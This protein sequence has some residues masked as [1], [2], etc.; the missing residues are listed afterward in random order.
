M[1]K[2]SDVVPVQPPIQQPQ[3]V[4]PVQY[5][6]PA[7]PIQSGQPAQPI[8]SGQPNPQMEQIKKSAT[9]YFSFFIQMLKAPVRTGQ[10]T[11]AGQMVNGLITMIVFSLML[12]LTIYFELRQAFKDVYSFFGSNTINLPAGDYIFKPFFVLIIA[13]LLVTAIMLLVL[14]LGRVVTNFKEV[15]AR[16]GALMVPA[17]A[18][19]TISFLFALIKIDVDLIGWLTMLGFF[20]WLVAICYTIYS[21]KKDQPD[22]L[23]TFYCL[24]LTFIGSFIVFAIFGDSILSSFFGGIERLY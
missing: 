16:F 4:P 3:Q 6:Q 2:P 10:Q 1:N 12:P 22:G 19:F 21:F 20:S 18:L 8:Q 17:A 9:D 5:G 14:K 7:Q 11:N 13:V 24:L 23:D 15:I